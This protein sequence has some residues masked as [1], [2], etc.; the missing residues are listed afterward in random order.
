[1]YATAAP[2]ADFAQCAQVLSCSTFLAFI[3]GGQEP[4]V[5][6]DRSWMRGPSI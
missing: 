1:M 2:A 6:A 5:E 4:G 3:Q